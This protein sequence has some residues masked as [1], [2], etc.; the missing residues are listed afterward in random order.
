M[1]FMCIVRKLEGI[2][3]GFLNYQVSISVLQKDLDDLKKKKKVKCLI[4][5]FIIKFNIFGF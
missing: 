5:A 1:D 4:F 2:P 3:N